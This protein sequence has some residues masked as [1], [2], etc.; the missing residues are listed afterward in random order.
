MTRREP[1]R[2]VDVVGDED[3]GLAGR[4]L[5][6]RELVLQGVAGDRVERG[7]RL[8]HQQEVGVGGERAGDPDALLLAAGQLVRVFA[9]IGLGVEAEQLP[10][11][12]RPGRATRVA[13]PAQQ[14]RHG[15]DVVLDP[16][17]RKQPDRLDRVADAPPQRLGRQRR[18]I[19][20]AD[21]D[22]AGCRTA[23]AG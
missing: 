7:E 2:L 21:P 16:P 10:A 5:D 11:A 4:L 13:R 8:V 23:R 18:D 6:A 17:M 1:Q 19:L 12:R 15:R 9:A 20:A 14:A 3:D 22:R